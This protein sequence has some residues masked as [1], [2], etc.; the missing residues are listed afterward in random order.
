MNEKTKITL[1]AKEQA[2]VCNTN[3]ILTKAKI[4]EKVYLLFGEIS[5]NAYQSFAIAKEHLPAAFFS[6]T[7]KIS[8][9]EN[10]QLLPYVVLDYPRHFDKENVLS[11]RTFFWW[12]NF[13]SISLHLSG[14]CK[15][16][17]AATLSDRFTFLQ[18]QDYWVCV[19]DTPWQHHFEDDNF[20][21]A[22]NMT[23]LQFDAILNND[24]FIKIAKKIPLQQWNSAKAFIE[25]TM[26]EMKELC[27]VH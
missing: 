9:G 26:G 8:K 27:S 20:I 2:L 1:S 18:L 7:A 5:S 15:I 10:Y 17:A 14:Q 13:F 24:S 23:R 25:M 12:G 3:W 19:H 11:I 22:K 4:I 16:D 6:T 21:T